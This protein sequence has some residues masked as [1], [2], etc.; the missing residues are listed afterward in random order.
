MPGEHHATLF[1]ELHK[2]VR[3]GRVQGPPASLLSPDLKSQVFRLLALS[4]CLPVI[5]HLTWGPPL[6]W[7]AKLLV[8]ALVQRKPCFR[9]WIMGMFIAHCPCVTLMIHECGVILPGT[10]PTFWS[11]FAL[12]FGS[13]GSV[14][15][16]LR[17]ADV[18]AFLSVSLLHTLAAHYVDKFFSVDQFLFAE[19]SFATFQ[20]FHRL[21]GFKMKEAKSKPPGTAHTL[22]GIDWTFSPDS[23]RAEPGPAR[24]S[25]LV[26]TIQGFLDSD[27]MS[28]SECSSLTGRPC[29]TCTWVF[30]HVGRSFLQPLYFR[31]HHG[32]PG[33]SK[34]TPRVRQALLQVQRLLDHV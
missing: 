10:P 11:H 23:V 2:E 25:R 6:W 33:P 1:A 12:P 22:L 20:A 24:I 32:N 8:R 13:V 14:W 28:A 15:G 21:L 5:A 31:Q 26:A 3:L 17:V 19:S 18:V 30:G 4:L 29:F 7:P 16:Y 34:L 9:R 27:M